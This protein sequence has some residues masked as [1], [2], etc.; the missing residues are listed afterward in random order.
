MAIAVVAYPFSGTFETVLAADEIEQS[1][2]SILRFE[3]GQN[4]V[5][6]GGRAARVTLEP[7]GD[8]VEVSVT[9]SEDDPTVSVRYLIF[10]V[11]PLPNPRR[12][13]ATI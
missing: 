8:A 10:L 4:V 1:R 11:P 9:P 13:E 2:Q 12:A 3:R 7:D 5:L 6:G